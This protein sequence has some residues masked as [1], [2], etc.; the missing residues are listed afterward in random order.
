MTSYDSIH[1]I[2]QEYS[3]PEKIESIS[4]EDFILARNVAEALHSATK[5]LLAQSLTRTECENQRTL[6]TAMAI[7]IQSCRRYLE[8]MAR[9]F[10]EV[11]SYQSM[12]AKRFDDA[13][14]SI[15]R[16]L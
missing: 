1:Q 8:E 7:K 6:R 10:G 11:K 15:S 5:D 3:T 2:I 4:E 9:K 12:D 13:A 14:W 16:S